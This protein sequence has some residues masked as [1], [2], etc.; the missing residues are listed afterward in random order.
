MIALEHLVKEYPAKH[1]TVRVLDDINLSV[2]DGEILAVVG[3]SGAGKSTLAACIN[4]LERPT[5]ETVRVN[6]HD[7]SRLGAREL[8]DARRRIG[9]IFQADGLQ[10]RRTAAENVG[11]P[12]RYLGLTERARKLRVAEL[13]D[14]VGLSDRADYYPHQLSGGQRQR[15]GIARAL[16]LRPNVLLS[17]EATSGLDPESTRSILRLLKELRA[18]LNLSVLFITHEMETVVDVADTVAR[19]DAGRVTEYGRLSELLVDGE[20]E[21][22]SALISARVNSAEL[23]PAPGAELWRV[24]YRSSHV[25]PDWLT[26]VSTQIGSPLSIL[27]ADIRVVHGSR[28]GY[29]VVQTESRCADDFSRSVSEY[30]LLAERVAPASTGEPVEAPHSDQLSDERELSGVL[31]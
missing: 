8:R 16:A 24:S 1:G 2:Q 13:L 17:D 30:G 10:G 19:I 29:A 4:L 31:A 21:V 26:A 6:G 18:E 3:P 7:L 20:S 23:Q 14:R 11:L 27:E 15:V 28:V 5:S 9:T 12:L 25:R 22:G